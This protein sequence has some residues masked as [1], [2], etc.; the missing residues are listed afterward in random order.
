MSPNYCLDWEPL[1]GNPAPGDDS[2][3]S[4]LASL[5]R[6][7]ASEVEQ[8]RHS[9]SSLTSHVNWESEA[10]KSFDGAARSLHDHLGSIEHRYTTVAQ[11]LSTWSS[12]LYGFQARAR[13]LLARAE[14]LRAP[15]APPPNASSK[16]QSVYAN[17]WLSYNSAQDQIF[18]EC[19]RL[20]DEYESSANNLAN[21]I[22]NVINNDGL[23]NNWWEDVEGA[24]GDFVAGVQHWIREHAKILE[25]IS[26]ILSTLSTIIGDIATI[27]QVVGF[28]LP[29]PLDAA[30]E[31]LGGVLRVA[32]ID[33]GAL[34]ILDDSALAFAGVKGYTL[35]TVLCD[36]VT[37]GLN[38]VGNGASNEADSITETATKDA[39]K[40]G[41]HE[42]YQVAKSDYGEYFTRKLG[43]AARADFKTEAE[44][45]GKE[46]EKIP[47]LLDDHPKIVGFLE[48]HS[49]KF[50]SSAIKD[51]KT[52]LQ[53]IGADTTTFDAQVKS[54][55]Q[56]TRVSKLASVTNDVWGQS[57]STFEDPYKYHA[58]G[59]DIPSD[60]SL[61]VDVIDL[62]KG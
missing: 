5:Y 34:Q 8:N 9:L 55:A 48:R 45:W 10:V 20:A 15:S 61:G 3:V 52:S 11:T 2:E 51:A 44:S 54:A 31:A 1:G 27:V 7:V 36:V 56:W 21:T 16:E 47:S 35:T 14:E 22:Q 18:A 38:L 19:Q 17:A 50:S 41:Q 39:L 23:A 6:N 32:Q 57:K 59:G 25:E 4:Y 30:A 26:K 28:F 53:D 12:E 60:P 42:A 33:L 49:S 43:Y 24:V 29:P 37:E 13:N 40:T 62:V 58:V 46:G